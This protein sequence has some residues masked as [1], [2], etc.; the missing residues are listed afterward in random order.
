MSRAELDRAVRERHH[1][2]VVGRHDDHPAR[3]GDLAQQ[4]QHALDLYVVE[5]GRGLVRKQQRRVERQRARD[6]DALLLAAGQLAGPVQAA[7]A[8]AHLGQQLLGAPAR[9]ARG[10]AGRPQRY[11]HVLRRGQARH[12]VE[13]LEDHPDAVAAVLGQ[14]PAAERR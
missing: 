11:L 1:P 4:P 2:L 7:P 9:P 10:H 14:R 8:E 12:Q 3:V 13:R 6:R 5:V